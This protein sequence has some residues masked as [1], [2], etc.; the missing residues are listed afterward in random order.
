[1]RPVPI[2]RTD[3][4]TGETTVMDMPCGA[5]LAS[6]CPSCAERKKRLRMTQCRE[7]WH[8]SEEP[9]LEPDPPNEE[10]RFLITLRA[11]LEK[12]HAQAVETGEDTIDIDQLID[13]ID[14]EITRAGMRGK[15]TP[16]QRTRRVRSTRR[17]HDAPDLPRRRIDPRTVGR[18]YASPDGT[19]FRPSMFVTLTCDS[20]GKVNPDGTPTDPESYDYQRAA[21]DALHFSK[22]T[23]R[24]VQNLRR[25]V[26]YD[27][28]YFASIEPQ[29]RLAPHVHMAI[30]GAISRAEL[31]QVVAAT[32]HHVWW[33][34]CHQPVYTDQLP[35]WDEQQDAYVDPK[36]GA[37]LPN[38]DDALDAL[39]A[40]PDTEPV[41]TVRFG[42]QVHAEGV[43]AGSNDASRCL[44]YLTKYLTKKV[45]ECHEPQT[46][47]QQA[48]VER[49]VEALRFE[50]C[51]PTCANWLRYGVQ[52][53]NPRPDMRP[54][55]CQ[56]KAHR[57]EHLGYGG[58]RV[59][60]SRKW[61]GKTLADHKND[62]RAW[63]LALLGIDQPDDD[64]NRYVWQPIGSDDPA[65]QPLTRRLLHAVAER[66]RWR[67][68]LNQ[69][70]GQPMPD[71]SATNP[72]PPQAA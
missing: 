32:Y 37:P 15:A 38:W 65:I 66:A 31:R 67:Q 20:Y 69:A 34:P 1:V 72:A 63:V 24:F 29:R 3:L 8:L 12:E 4:V 23:D 11:D 68:A 2:R 28:Q 5:T 53:K 40:D 35:I 18:T 43:L 13:E 61:S 14:A 33:P 56:G 59:L 58:R 70:T 36:A 25:V 54:G 30:R 62:R 26:G 22:L 10:Q 47:E 17:R 39:D 41:H 60:V 27:I 64:P 45:D 6:V 52:P 57:R 7:G 48:H 55:S 42:R 19:T 71:F 49:L 16:E 50:P 46:P 44:G 51:S 9:I 21:R